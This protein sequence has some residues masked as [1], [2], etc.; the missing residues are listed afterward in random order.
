MGRHGGH[1]S[2]SERN[3]SSR[4]SPR[5]GVQLFPSQSR[6]ECCGAKWPGFWGGTVDLRLRSLQKSKGGRCSNLPEKG[7]CFDNCC[8]PNSSELM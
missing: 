2:L 4:E 1:A 8:F 5:R 6:G 7:P 3:S